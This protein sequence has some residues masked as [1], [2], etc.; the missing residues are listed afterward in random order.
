MAR[1]ALWLL[2]GNRPGPEQPPSDLDL[3]RLHGCVGPDG[4][5]PYLALFGII[6]Y[7][8]AIRAAPP[9]TLLEPQESTVPKVAAAQQRQR[10]QAEASLEEKRADEQLREGQARV[11]SAIEHWLAA[12]EKR[13]DGYAHTPQQLLNGEHQSVL[14]ELLAAGEAVDKVMALME[15]TRRQVAPS[16]LGLPKAE[17]SLHLNAQVRRLSAEGHS[18]EEIAYVMGW[19][20]GTPQ[21]IRDRTRKRLEYDHE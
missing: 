5:V 8:D 9:K 16:A 20:L 21:Q 6:L 2:D 1:R 14:A 3:D 7:Q 15:A 19:Y 12:S 13:A 10:M 11:H 4:F 17:R 18:L